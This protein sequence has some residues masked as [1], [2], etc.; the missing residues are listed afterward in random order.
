ML[1]NLSKF[2]VVVTK[3]MSPGT[4]ASI[5]QHLLESEAVMRVVS[6]NANNVYSEG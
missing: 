4:Q 6:E 2:M 1:N 3:L 5:Y